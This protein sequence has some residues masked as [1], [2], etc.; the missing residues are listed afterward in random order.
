VSRR[1][2]AKRVAQAHMRRVAAT[3]GE[4]LAGLD[5]E[6]SRRS[7]T[8]RPQGGPQRWTV[9]DHTVRVERDGED[10]RLSCSCDFW[11]YQGPEYHARQGGY[12]L[13]SPRGT[14]AAPRVRDPQGRHLVCK[15]AAAVLGRLERS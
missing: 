14:A 3:P 11:V 9:G 1:L 10:I 8:L 5:R 13:G 2:L 15:H 6:I 12:L 7:Q 4:V